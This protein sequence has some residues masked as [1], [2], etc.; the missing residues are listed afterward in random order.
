[1]K[2]YFI[3]ILACLCALPFSGASDTQTVSLAGEWRFALDRTDIGMKESWFLKDL[4]D[5]IKLPGA[6]QEQG[7][8][9]EITATTEWTAT[10][11]DKLWYL[12]P[13]Y[14]KYTQPGNVKIPFFLQPDKRYVGAAWYQ[15]DIRV[16]GQWK[17]RRIEL[18]LE[19]PHWETRVW[20]DGDELGANNSLSTAHVYSL[21]PTT[22]PGTHRLTMRVDNRMIVDVGLDAHSVTDH[23][24]GNWNGIT[25]RIELSSRSP[26]WIADVRVFSDVAKKSAL[27]RIS[28]GNVTGRASSGTLSVRAQRITVNW[29]S[30]GGE[31]ELEV[32]LGENAELWDEFHPTLHRL[33]IRLK[34]NGV[35][36]EQTVTFG[37][38]R[39]ATEGTQFT[40]NGRKFFVRGTLECAVF[41]RT[42]YPPTDVESW[43]RII[44]ICKEYGL[45]LIRF[46]SWCPPE[47]AFVA[48]D[49]LGFYYQVE[50]GMWV[51]R[52][53]SVLGKGKSNDQWLYNESERIIKA[54]GN[55]PSF[56]MLVHGNEP[57]ADLKFLANWV[58]YWKERDPRRLYS[59]ATGWAM[60]DENQFH[61]TMAVPGR[62]QMRVR[63]I[64]GWNGR[65]YREAH[66]GAKVPIIS[67]EI[68]QFCSYPDF[69]QIAK[70]TGYLK[71]NNFIIFRDSLAE[72]GMLAQDR[73]FV[74]ASGHLQALCYKEEIEAAQRTPGLGG[75][76][77]LD[78]HDFPGQGTALIGVLDAFWDSKGY[79][80][81]A[82][83]RRFCNTTVPLARLA[84]RSWTTGETLTADLEVAHFGPEPLQN[85]V[86]EW[87]LEAQDGK[88]ALRDEFP[89]R[90]VPLG[91]GIPVG[92]LSADLTKLPAPAEYRLV[93]RIRGTTFENDWS[94]WLYPARLDLTPPRDVLVASKLDDQVRTRLEAGGKVLLLP[95]SELSWADPPIA[96]TPVF[97]NLQMFPRWREQTVGLLCDPG[98]PALQGFPTKS[99]TEW[100]WADV[101]TRSRAM[102]LDGLP[103]G[104]RPVVQVIDDWNR[105]RRLALLFECRVGRGS[106]LVCS[107]DLP[108][109]DERAS[110]RQFYRSLLDYAAG[111]RFN[112]TVRLSLDQ[113]GSLLDDT[114]LMK[115]LGARIYTPA[116]ERVSKPG[117]TYMREDAVAVRPGAGRPL[118]NLL[119]GDPGTSW[120]SSGEGGFPREFVVEFPKPVRVS[121]IRCLPTQ[122]SYD[123]AI[124]SYAVQV[125]QDLKSWSEAARGTFELSLNEQRVRFREPETMRAFKLVA[126]SGYGDRPAASLAE[127]S[128]IEAK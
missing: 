28:L 119:D 15:R 64:S 103:Q 97:W 8:G 71:P 120:L 50:C 9:D 55:H 83:F 48:A 116:A 43:K 63:G 24:Q 19:R 39:I 27:L 54:Y 78:L 65:D 49:E 34:G 44:R 74:S 4:P 107:A 124:R 25:G 59:S 100:N 75:F 77:L 66:E 12:K 67:H 53:G 110:A 56:T 7:Y 20:L 23:T 81:P 30:K 86:F 47:A 69:G 111:E 58:K 99:Y 45:N 112:P 68:G 51:R 87:T 90:V 14:Q 57:T 113:I 33:E 18:L 3:T 61:A 52:A 109:L 26:V 101:L 96:F 62:D 105:N 115:K 22:A 72:H 40:M 80:T 5:R 21:P 122:D 82:E 16:P 6:L 88:V 10:L 121:G 11:Y 76:E 84:K 108:H 92:R 118:Q 95:F 126:L 117:E 98:H 29:D 60:T 79:V 35:E 91:N 127:I 38:R 125:S 106:L 2:N 31:A 128:I 102:V 13:Q 46:H 42:G 32:P 70:Y 93:L 37:L 94:V 85:A 36:D 1:M 123:G 73:D 17:G 89:S 41:P 114:S 104:V